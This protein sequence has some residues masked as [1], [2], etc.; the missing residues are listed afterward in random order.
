M[1]VS[2]SI[3]LLDVLLLLLLVI[4]G[5]QTI[6]LLAPQATRIEAVAAGLP[7][8]AGL[9]TFTVFMVSWAGIEIRLATLAAVYVCLLVPLVL[10]RRLKEKRGEPRPKKM[11]SPMPAAHRLALLAPSALIGILTLVSAVISVGRSY[12]PFDASAIWA[13]K[14]YG[15]ALEGTIFAARSW[16]AHALTYPLNIPILISSFQL[17]DGDVLPGSKLVFPLLFGSILAGAVG[18]WRRMGMTNI[19]VCVGVLFLGTLPEVFRHSTY[20]YVNIPAS[21]YLVLGTIW[22]VTGVTSSSRQHMTVAGFL[23]A[24]GCWTR[25]EGILYALVIAGALAASWLLL[26]PGP[27]PILWLMAP[28]V[29]IGGTWLIFL[30]TYGLEGS[31]PGNAMAAAFAGWRSGDLRLH[32]LRLIFGYFRR[33]LLDSGTWGLLF[34]LSAAFLAFHLRRR[35]GR[36]SPEILP[37]ALATFGCGFVTAGLFYVGSYARGD[38]VGWLTRGF[39][40][41]FFPAAILL[42]ILSFV[43]GATDGPS[44]IA[45]VAPSEE[46]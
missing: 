25:V 21:A 36:S 43:V 34:P 37:L 10:G 33:E 6:R 31:Q 23:L 11:G 38:L 42:A 7:L 2:P 40:R 8:G 15:I 45:R 16:G 26:R 35:S 39:P 24:L 28:I 4:L 9:L 18:F 30:R 13:S 5:S 1:L 44:L 19:W 32:S 17:V 29:V 22:G 41:A 12:T 46:T 3:L 20:G 27:F 14:G